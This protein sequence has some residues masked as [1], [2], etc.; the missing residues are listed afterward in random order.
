MDECKVGR[1]RDIY[2]YVMRR[3]CLS[4]T[5]RHQ[6]PETIIF[7]VML[8]IFGP[9]HRFGSIFTG[10]HW[11]QNNIWAVKLHL[12]RQ[13]SHCYTASHPER[14]SPSRLCWGFNFVFLFLFFGNPA[15]PSQVLSCTLT[16]SID[17]RITILHIISDNICYI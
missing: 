14:N 7:P 6:F 2:T 1:A 10:A 17:Q 12:T 4:G 9:K 5:A 15:I 13:H 11:G 16:L 8:R 3:F